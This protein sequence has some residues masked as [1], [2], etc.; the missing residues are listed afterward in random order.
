MIQRTIFYKV[1]STLLIFFSHTTVSAIT[2]G[3]TNLID[4]IDDALVLI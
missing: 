4:L 3:T 2:F 1:I